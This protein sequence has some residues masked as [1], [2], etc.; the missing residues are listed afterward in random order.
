MPCS[1]RALFPAPDEGLLG[2][3]ETTSGVRLRLS[4]ESRKLRLSFQ[5]LPTTEPAVG[6][7]GFHFDLTIERD[8]V[9]STAVPPGGEEAVFDDLPAG[10]KIVEIWLSQEVPVALKTAL[11]GDEACRQANDTRP[12]WVTY[13]SSLTHCARA[14]SPA[15]TYPAAIVGLVQIIRDKHPDTPIALVSPMGFPPHETVPNAVN[16]TSEG[17]RRDMEDVHRRLLS[18]GDRNLI[19]VDGL[20]VFDLEL[21]ERYTED[22]CHPDGDGIEVQAD[23]FDR[24]VMDRL[25]PP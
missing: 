24:A 15:R 10:D 19:Y 6:R 12:R 21:I 2:R 5:S 7:S 25:L 9:A 8:L 4:T 23:R 14:H 20:E 13:G 22:Q 17:M 16:Y 1:R 18:L 3:A 11:E